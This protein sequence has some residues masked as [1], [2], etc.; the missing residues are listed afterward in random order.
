M[1][2]K[3]LILNKIKKHKN[4][5]TNKDFAEFLGVKTTTLSMWHKRNTMDIELLFN[6]CEY[7]DANWLLTGEG[8]MLKQEQPKQE[9]S[10]IDYKEKYYKSLEKN[11][12]LHERIDALQQKLLNNTSNIEDNMN[13][14][15]G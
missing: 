7:I 8:E 6:K 11:T 4:F 10:N 13:R 15:V 3:S 2:D 1:I 12:E 9:V 5:K 14:S